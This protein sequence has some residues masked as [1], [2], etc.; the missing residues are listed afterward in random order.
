MDRLVGNKYD[1]TTA[2]RE[3]G[4]LWEEKNLYE[5]AKESRMKGKEFYFLD[6]LHGI[7]DLASP[8]VV[9][10]MLV[11]D[12][13]IRY[14]RMRGYNVRDRAGFE[15]YVP[16]AERR[17]MESLGLESEEDIED[18]GREKYLNA[19]RKE[20]KEMREEIADF[21][22]KFGVW[23]DWRHAYTPLDNKYVEGVWHA[24]KILSEKGLVDR[25]RGIGQ[26]CPHCKTFLSKSEIKTD[27]EWKRGIYAKFP[28]KGRKREYLVVW[29]S[30]PWQLTATVSLEVLPS[31]KYSLIDLKSRGER[32]IVGSDE[33]KKVL[34]ASGITKYEIAGEITGKEILSMKYTHP[35]FGTEQEE[36][37]ISIEEI[38]SEELKIDRILPGRSGGMSGIKAVVPAH[39]AHDLGLAERNSVPVITPVNEEGELGEDT[40]KYAGFDIFE[41]ESIIVR[42]LVNT[43]MA[44][45]PYDVRESV[46]LCGRCN[47]RLIPRIS[48]EWSF[49]PSETGEKSEEMASEIEWFP[50]WMMGGDYDWMHETL[51]V[52]I[53]RKGYWGVPM[54]VWVCSCGHR[55]VVGSAK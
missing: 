10:S 37:V 33:A 28:L 30:E 55:E 31:K 21:F 29:F 48:E 50:A 36:D 16:E 53:S 17:A 39:S 19:C 25:F 32:I 12:A 11:K 51:P 4:E 38:E 44:L 27:M 20:A 23:L 40:G 6:S 13:M 42:D 43:G 5:K 1:P 52:P 47:N 46:R 18:I 22:K 8:D 3:I 49:K 2:E 34:E 15:G 54:P 24:F 45:S 35:L 7:S 41:A 9:Y 14:L 26:W